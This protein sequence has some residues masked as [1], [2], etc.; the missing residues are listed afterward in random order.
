MC[1][2]ATR[3]Y[4]DNIIEKKWQ[5]S[6]SLLGTIL[7]GLNNM[8]WLYLEDKHQLPDFIIKNFLLRGSKKSMIETVESR[9]RKLEG[10][11]G[12]KDEPIT[13]RIYLVTPLKTGFLCRNL[14]TGK[15]RHVSG[16]KLGIEQWVPEPQPVAGVAAKSEISVPVQ[17]VQA[18]T[19]EARIERIRGLIA[20]DFG[21]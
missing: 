21:F 3:G 20:Q 17:P 7:R 13:F 5:R 11:A 9:V 19:P 2:L 15:S 6:M 1:A 16:E 12:Q 10:K 8:G 18:E 4:I 14:K